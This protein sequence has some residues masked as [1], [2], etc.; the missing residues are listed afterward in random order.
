MSTSWV[1]ALFA[2]PIVAIIVI[3]AFALYHSSEV[4]QDGRDDDNWKGDD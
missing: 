4:Q 3:V 2:L 1:I